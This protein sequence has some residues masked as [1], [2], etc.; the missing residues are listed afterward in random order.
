MGAG[1]RAHLVRSH[2]KLKLVNLP[3]PADFSEASLA[4]ALKILQADH[5]GWA[6]VLVHQAELRRALKVANAHNLTK[7]KVKIRVL[8]DATLGMHDWRLRSSTA[9]VRS[10]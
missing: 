9:E 4:F 5:E 2:P 1:D 8:T 7:P 3:T 6:D 10:S